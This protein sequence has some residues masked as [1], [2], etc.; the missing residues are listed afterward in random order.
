MQHE[1]CGLR[2]AACCAGIGGAR[3][4]QLGGG[5]GGEYDDGRRHAGRGDSKPD[6]VAPRL[7]LARGHSKGVQGRVMATAWCGDEAHVS[8]MP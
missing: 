5:A 1:V 4:S 3:A 8:R 6:G 2:R 7:L